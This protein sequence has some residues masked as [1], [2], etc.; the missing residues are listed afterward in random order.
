MAKKTFIGKVVS[1]KM[2][3][4]VI[5]QIERLVRH[6]VYKKILKRTTKIKA[7]TNN[8]EVG[9]GQS[10]KIEQARPMS[11]DKHFKV[12]EVLNEEKK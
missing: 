2:Q 6:P 4:T 11:R 5:V 1:N 8:F 3:K 12:V 7:D 10:V 9:T